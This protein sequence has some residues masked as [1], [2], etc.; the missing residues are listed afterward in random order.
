MSK[1]Q[2]QWQRF[3][4]RV[5][6]LSNWTSSSVDLEVGKDSIKLIRYSGCTK[7]GNVLRERD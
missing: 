6:C 4:M 7:W 1:F 5:C 3:Q 2:A